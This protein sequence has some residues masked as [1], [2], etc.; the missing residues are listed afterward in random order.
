[1]GHYKTLLECICTNNPM[2]PS[3]II[4]IAYISLIIASPLSC[5]NTASQVML[6][7]GKGYFIENL[8]II[9]LCEADLNF[10]FH[11]IWGHRL[12]RHA[13]SHQ[14]LDPA[15]YTLPGQICNNAVLKK[16]LFFN[17]SRQTLS[18]GILLDFDATAA[19]DRV[20]AGLS[21]E[22]CKRV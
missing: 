3:L 18:L 17:L 7:K 2:I 21:I 14:A 15:Q 5:W 9:Q 8:C 16:T 22:T 19:F 10:V 1:M 6:E 13:S 20:I 11:F 12:F 4:D